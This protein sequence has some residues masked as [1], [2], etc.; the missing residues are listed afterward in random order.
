MV[1]SDSW[2]AI[3]HNNVHVDTTAMHEQWS[4]FQNLIIVIF[5][6]FH[7]NFFFR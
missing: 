4:F 1:Q 3:E 6:Y 7:P 2:L 5:G